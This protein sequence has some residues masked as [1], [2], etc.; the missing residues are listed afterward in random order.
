MFIGGHQFSVVDGNSTPQKRPVSEVISNYTTLTNTNW[1]PLIAIRKKATHGPSN[2][3][4]SVKF[5]LKGY[6][7]T[8]DS[9]METRITIGGTTTT[10]S[11]G[12]PT[13]WTSSETALESKITGQ[14]VL[15]ASP[16][17]YP[18]GYGFAT[19]NKNALSTV[20]KD[21]SLPIGSNNE[22]IL[23]IRRLSGTGAM[24]VKQAH[25]DWE[26]EW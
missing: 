23:W 13:G 6:E 19:S 18:G 24:I 2:R 16:D 26:E 25:L 20:S 9:E 5:Y 7:V 12:T 22:I 1:Q 14:Y 15:T 4:T 11:F 10:G 8:S 21:E 3:P 17:G